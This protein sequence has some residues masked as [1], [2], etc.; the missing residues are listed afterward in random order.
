MIAAF[1]GFLLMF[2]LI[3]LSSVL[4]SRSTRHDYYLADSSVPRGWSDC[5]LSPQTTAA[6]CLSALSATPTPLVLPQSG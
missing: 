1:I 2:T 6:I 3:G 5:P 4:K